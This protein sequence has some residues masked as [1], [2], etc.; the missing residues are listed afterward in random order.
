MDNPH[1]CG[2]AGYQCEELAKELSK[3]M[4]CKDNWEG[5]NNGITNFDNFGLAMLTVFQCV[6]LEGWTDVL[7]SVSIVQWA[8]QLYIIINKTRNMR[9]ILFYII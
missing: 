1:P 4:V 3:N 6:T 9:H 8:L 5:P 2:E 7:Y